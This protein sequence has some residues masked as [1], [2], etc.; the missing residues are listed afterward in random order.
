MLASAVYLPSAE[1]LALVP[2]VSTLARTGTS[3]GCLVDYDVDRGEVVL[4]AQGPIKYG[5]AHA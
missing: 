3:A 1:C 5:C 2:G 4:T